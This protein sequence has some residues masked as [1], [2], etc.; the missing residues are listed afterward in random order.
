ML[1]TNSFF[2]SISRAIFFWLLSAKNTSSSSVG[3]YLFFD[4]ISSSVANNLFADVADRASLAEAIAS[5]LDDELGTTILA[6]LF[7]ESVE[8]VYKGSLLGLQ[9]SYDVYAT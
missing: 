3:P 4:S 2:S 7:I 8:A 6:T 9:T 5:C 1:P